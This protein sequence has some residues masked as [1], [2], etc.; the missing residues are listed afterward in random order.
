MTSGKRSV[1]IQNNF[2]VGGVL[3]RVVEGQ[4]S[5]K[6]KVFYFVCALIVGIQAGTIRK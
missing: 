6:M 4:Q 1:Y 5:R 2:P 3:F